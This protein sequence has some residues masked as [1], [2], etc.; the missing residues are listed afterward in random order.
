MATPTIN[1][2]EELPNGPIAAALVAGGIGSAVIG[3]M[4]VLNEA[5]PA[6]SNTLKWVGPV[7]PLSGKTGVGVIVFFVSWIV[8]HV[9]YRGKNVDFA[10]FATIALILLG[11]GLLGTFP[12]FFDLFA[13]G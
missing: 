12:P 11:L 13:A 6:I 7:G 2:A 10:R 5:S 1:Q 4:T 3:L 8:L 9:I